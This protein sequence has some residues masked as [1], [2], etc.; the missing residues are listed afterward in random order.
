MHM[1]NK[2]ILALLVGAALLA[3]EIVVVDAANAEFRIRCER[4]GNR[5]SR[6]S[7]DGK[8]LP[9]GTYSIVVT[10]GPTNSAGATETIVAPADEFESDF[11]SNRADIRAGATPI[12]KT[13]I[14]D[15]K[16]SVQVTGPESLPATEFACRIR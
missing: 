6:I 2:K 9:A 7:V 14:V 11:D 3:A 4:R 1:V 10:S 15:R 12:A 5:R 16:V 8:N 13:F